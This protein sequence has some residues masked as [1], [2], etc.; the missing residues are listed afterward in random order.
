M[1]DFEVASEIFVR[2][3]LRLLRRGDLERLFRYMLR[4]PLAADRLCWKDASSNTE[5]M[6][7]L[8]RPWSDGT[9]ALVMSPM[10]S[11]PAYLTQVDPG[12]LSRA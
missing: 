2:R 5:L 11:G 6:L 3:L 8:K 1:V 9:I 12:F 7:E 4:P 10:V